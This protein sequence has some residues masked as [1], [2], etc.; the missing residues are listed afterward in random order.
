MYVIKVYI[1]PM[2][3]QFAIKFTSKSMLTL[4]DNIKMLTDMITTELDCSYL[5][6]D[7]LLQGAANWMQL[8]THF[9]SGLD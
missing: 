5:C 3:I 4:M 2:A 1:L 7:N 8:L 9:E 6:T